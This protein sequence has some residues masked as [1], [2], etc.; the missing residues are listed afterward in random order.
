MKTL[1]HFALVVSIAAVPAS[2]PGAPAPEPAKAPV[3]EP[4]REPASAPSKDAA[5]A[6]AKTPPPASKSLATPPVSP[7][8]KL[9]RERIDALFRYRNEPPSPPDPRLSPFRPAGAVPVAATPASSARDPAAGD[10]PLPAP[11][12]SDLALLQQA[13]ATLKVSGVV[14]KAGQAHLVINAK[15]YKVGEVIQTKVQGESVF[16]RVRNISRNSITLGLNG[17]EMTL[18]F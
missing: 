9:V 17:A 11:L 8:F 10:A 18:K 1:R 14:E 3:T 12:S 2:L 6:P 16:L 13:V 4:A 7:R 15:P 5:G